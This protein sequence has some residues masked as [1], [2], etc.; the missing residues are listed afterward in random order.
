MLFTP[1]WG[2][3]LLY[4]FKVIYCLQG[5]TYSFCEKLKHSSTFS[6]TSVFSA[7]EQ[8]SNDNSDM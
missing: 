7:D 2:N 5:L 3:K 6:W 4:N 1:V 8:E